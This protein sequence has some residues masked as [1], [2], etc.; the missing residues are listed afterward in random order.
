VI[1][2]ATPKQ[3]VTVAAFGNDNGSSNRMSQV[4]ES[5]TFRYADGRFE[6]LVRT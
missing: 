5:S 4:E 6:H 3:P 2:E 1:A